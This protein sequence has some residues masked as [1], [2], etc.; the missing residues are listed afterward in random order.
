VLLGTFLWALA[1]IQIY[2][3]PV[4]RVQAT[5]W[6]YDN[7][8]SGAT[9]YYRT[10]DGQDGQMQLPVPSQQVYATNGG[11]YQTPFVP[12]DDVTATEIV[13]ND[14]TGQRGP[15]AGAFEARIAGV[16][17]NDEPLS[18]A[19]IEGVFGEPDSTQQ[20]IDLPDVPLAR[21]QIYYFESR[22]LDG[23]PL[24]ASGATLRYRTLDG[25]TS[26]IALALPPYQVYATNRG[27]HSVSFTPPSDMIATQ[28]VMND[29][30]GQNGPVEGILEAR[31]AG[32]NPGG[33]PLPCGRARS[34]AL[35]PARP[36]P[37]R[38]STSPTCP[39]KAA[40]PTGSRAGPC[41]ARRWSAAAR[42]LPTSI[43][44]IRCPSTCLATA[45]LAAGSIAAWT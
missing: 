45:P 34:R 25:Q 24:T 31:V 40:R 3:E 5:R 10:L 41:A 16:G 35:S 26:E 43:S 12:P 29:L 32:D 30:S 21:G 22:A 13:M 1:F 33:A 42:S 2:T 15:V 23:A 4:T 11:W 17:P 39:C 14:L 6:I 20:I 36:W 28:L 8:P 19:Q 27:W 18:E 37:A 7:V 38:S 9:L 44:T